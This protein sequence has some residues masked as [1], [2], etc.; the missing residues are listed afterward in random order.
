LLFAPAEILQH[1]L[2]IH[3]YNV[4]CASTISQA[5]A[6]EALTNGKDDASA[7][8]TEYKKRLDYCSVRLHQMG[9]SFEQPNGAF[10]LFIP[11]KQFNLSSYEFALKLLQNERIAVVPG[12]AFSALGEGYIRISYAA[13]LDQ[14]E[15]GMDGLETFIQTLS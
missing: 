8:R 12:D 3:Q 14:L 15:K 10:Y 5:A 1:V 2:K 7:M 13:S 4:T 6:I 9:L 11:V